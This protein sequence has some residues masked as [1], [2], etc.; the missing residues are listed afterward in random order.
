MRPPKPV[1]PKPNTISSQ[2]SRVAGNAQGRASEF[3]KGKTQPVYATSKKAKPA[4]PAKGPGRG[5]LVK[6]PFVKPPKKLGG[7]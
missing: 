5:K 3:Y 7:R 2:D 1:R 6:T 4:G